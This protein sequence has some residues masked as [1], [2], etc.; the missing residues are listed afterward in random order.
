M[1]ALLRRSQWCRSTTSP[2]VVHGWVHNGLFPFG[3]VPG[4][5]RFGCYDWANIDQSTTHAAHVKQYSEIH[6]TLVGGAAAATCGRGAAGRDVTCVPGLELPPLPP[7]PTM[8]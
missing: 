1:T 2:K 5:L 8:K 7:G 4:G 6:T 3:A